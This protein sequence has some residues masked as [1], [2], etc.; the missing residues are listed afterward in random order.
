MLLGAIAWSMRQLAKYHAAVGGG[1]S[2][3]EAARAAG[4][5]QPQ[6]AR[7][8]ASRSKGVRSRDVE[9]W[10]LVLAETDLALK[11]SRR[12]PDAVLEEMLTRLCRKG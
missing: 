3:D 1:A 7:E 2:P 5:Y 11:S 10:L 8:L 12:P 4:A 9:R 6:R